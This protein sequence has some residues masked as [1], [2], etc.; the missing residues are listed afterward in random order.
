VGACRLFYRD[1]ELQSAENVGRP[2]LLRDKDQFRLLLCGHKAVEV[3]AVCVLLMVQGDL[4][5]VTLTHLGI[6]SKTGLLGVVPL[7]GV[8]FTQHTRHLQNRWTSSSL[9]A[10]CTFFA[11]AIIHASHY[12]G[13]YTEAALTAVGAFLFSLGISFTPLGKRIDHLAETLVQQHRTAVC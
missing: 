12:P 6:A 5:G 13:V 9:V 10:I 7:L 4:A 1:D 2:T 11:D 8:T 3:A